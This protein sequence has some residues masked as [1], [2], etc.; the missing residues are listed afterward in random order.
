MDRIVGT[1]LSDML[2]SVAEVNGG[3]LIVAGDVYAYRNV[4]GDRTAPRL[5]ELL[6]VWVRLTAGDDGIIIWD[7]AY[8]GS[9]DDECRHILPVTDGGF[10]LCGESR[11]VPFGSTKTAE[12]FGDLDAWVVAIDANGNQLWDTSVGGI[13]KDHAMETVERPD[14]NCYRGIQ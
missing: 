7:K 8:G 13:G 1:T 14:G 5:G 6:D 3:D 10:V 2:W 4:D 9:S 12:H 11:S